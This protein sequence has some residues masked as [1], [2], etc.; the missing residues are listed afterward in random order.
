MQ[1]EGSGA[2]GEPRRAWS[3]VIV[4]FIKIDKK[5]LCLMKMKMMMKIMKM[6]MMTNDDDFQ[7]KFYKNLTKGLF[8]QKNNNRIFGKYF[9]LM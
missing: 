3:P 7:M 1:Q 5:L 9:Q 6:M 2:G 8:C 4:R